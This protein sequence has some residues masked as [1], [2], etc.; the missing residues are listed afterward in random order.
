MINYITGT[1]TEINPTSVTIET[2]GIGYFINIS[3]NTF[4]KL[5]GK[6]ES[7]ILVHEVIRE[8]AHQLFGFADK[9]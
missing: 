1:I 5:D 4:S 9:E 2:G 6:S 8:D 7:K 3:V